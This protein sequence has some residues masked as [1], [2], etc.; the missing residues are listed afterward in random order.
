MGQRN[1][2]LI[3]FIL[4]SVG[5]VIACS[6]LG[7][8]AISLV[9]LQTV[10]ASNDG[11]L[12]CVDQNGNGVIDKDEAINVVLAFF[13]GE[14]IPP[15]ASGPTPGP[16]DQA[17]TL[18]RLM[19]NAEE[20]EYAIGKRG[21]SLTYNHYRWAPYFQPGHLNRC[22][23]IGRAGSPLRGSHRD[24]LADQPGGAGPGQFLGTFRRRPDLDLPPAGRRSL[25]RRNALHRP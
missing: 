12:A 6:V 5:I 13:S 8:A 19:R 2:R 1:R 10:A 17:A 15:P 3:G 24:L 4:A 23:V 9:S 20:F 25:A 7:L 14:P 11:S 18:A 21:G 16:A 22:L